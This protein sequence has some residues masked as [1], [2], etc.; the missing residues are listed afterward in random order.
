[1]V[2]LES[3][4]ANDHFP[5]R[6]FAKA[7]LLLKNGRRLEGDYLEP[8]WSPTDQ[9]TAD[10]LRAKFHTVAAPVLGQARA[11]AI[12][13]AIDALDKTPLSNLWAL[14]AQPIN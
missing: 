3:D 2:M 8:K 10:E 11:D 7:T 9:P 12:E 14:L 13:E 1:M 4:Y 6:R 5:Q